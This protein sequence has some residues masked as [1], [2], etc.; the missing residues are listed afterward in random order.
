VLGGYGVFG[1]RIAAALAE[2]SD[3]S[4]RVAGR[5]R[6]AGMPFA[7]RI[8]AAF[9]ACDV[10]DAAAVEG[11]VRGSHVVIH[12]AGPFQGRDYRVAQMC[13]SSG[14]HYLDIADAREFVTGI[15]S[16][17]EQARAGGVFV[18]SGA[19]SVPAIT[20]AMTSTLR[21]E[22]DVVDEIE[23]TLSP[24]NQNPRGASTIASIL[25]YL[26]RPL[27][28]WQ[29]GRWTSS[30]GWGNARWLRLPAPVGWRR[31]H[32]CEAP[33][34]ELF[35]AAFDA[36]TVRFRAGVELNLINYT[37]SG[38]AWLRSSCCKLESL[39]RQAACFL[40]LSRMLLPLGSPHGVLAVELRGRAPGG[41]RLVRK[42]AL[43]TD[44]DGPAVACAPAILLARRILDHGPPR[45]G[46]FPCIGFLSLDEL[47]AYLRP[48]GVR[49]VQ[50]DERGWQ[51]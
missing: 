40:R 48:L 35:H 25:T 51:T 45:T 14:A 7:R 18:A 19:S 46:A 24:G 36:R 34:L 30:P 2:L 28:V 50:G 32:N 41:T 29:D 9:H 49:C 4:V 33:D 31:V 15:S 47:M 13:I 44:R 43:V 6:R 10:T 5:D 38:L 20:Y 16:L 17:D 27:A 22:F 1:G 21:P 42:L 12:T 8:G 39:P 37:L 3:V 23:V 26:G 11:A